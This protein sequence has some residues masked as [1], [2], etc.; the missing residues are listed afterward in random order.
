MFACWNI[1][2]FFTAGSQSSDNVLAG[3]AGFQNIVNKSGFSG[4]IL[5]D[6][7]LPVAV[8]PLQDLWLN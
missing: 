5:F 8:F 1:D 2:L 3:F 6:I 4:C 7:P